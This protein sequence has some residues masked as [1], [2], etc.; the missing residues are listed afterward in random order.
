MG[1]PEKH[2]AFIHDANTDAKRADL[3]EKM[4]NGDISVLIGSTF[5]MG[6]GVNVQERL[7][8]IHHLD[9]PWRP[10]DMVQREGRILRQGNKNSKVEI[11]RY[12][13]RGSFDAYLW[14]LLETKQ[15]FISQIRAGRCPHRYS[16]IPWMSPI[17]R[18]L[19]TKELYHC[20]SSTPT[21]TEVAFTTA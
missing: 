16:Y 20:Y 6:L 5:K 18:F 7:K 12:I 14:Q 10:A 9:V 11:F 3:F 8:A 21:M 13:T 4:I 19:A 15:R 1:I 17:M 2:V